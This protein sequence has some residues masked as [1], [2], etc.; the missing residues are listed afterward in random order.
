[1]NW[2]KLQL[3]KGAK[4]SLRKVFGFA[5]GRMEQGNLAVTLLAKRTIRGNEYILWKMDAKKSGSHIH[6]VARGSVWEPWPAR[7][8]VLPGKRAGAKEMILGGKNKFKSIAAL[9]KRRGRE[10]PF[11][12]KPKQ[13]T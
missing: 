3:K 12:L 13:T 8:F 4:A 1:M 9:S 10:K 6:Y 11:L 5:Q 2:E 7:T